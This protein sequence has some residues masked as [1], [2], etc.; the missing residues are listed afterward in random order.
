MRGPLYSVSYDGR[1]DIATGNYDPHANDHLTGPEGY[2]DSND[3]PC[4][5]NLGFAREPGNYDLYLDP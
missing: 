3:L 1:D 2:E 4:F 5:L